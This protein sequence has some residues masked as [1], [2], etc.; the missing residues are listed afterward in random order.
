MAEVLLEGEDPLTIILLAL[1]VDDPQFV[2]VV[3]NLQPQA[4]VA[5]VDMPRMEVMQG[6]SVAYLFSVLLV[7]HILME[8]PPTI[9]VPGPEALEVPMDRLE[10]KVG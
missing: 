1:E 10:M 8:V 7:V 5:V 3:M 2:E 9:M 4:V 6:V